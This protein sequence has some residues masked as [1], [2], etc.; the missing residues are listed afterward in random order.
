MG[1][2]HSIIFLHTLRSARR[3][4]NREI[5]V[6]NQ[7]KCRSPLNNREKSLLKHIIFM[8][9]AYSIGWMPLYTARVI[10]GEEF[11]T[12]TIGNYLTILPILSCCINVIDI[13]VYHYEF[14]AFLRKCVLHWIKG[15]DR[16]VN[17]IS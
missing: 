12:S 13:I 11:Q 6:E 7:A 9:I 8:L 17:T 5:T 4:T 2:I 10:L 16:Q 3:V 14:R 15:K 1:L